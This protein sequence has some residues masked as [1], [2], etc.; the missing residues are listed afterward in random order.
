MPIYEY[1]CETCAKPFALRQSIQIRPGETAC[2]VCGSTHV[3]RLISHFAAKTYGSADADPSGGTSCT[4]GG[5][6]GGN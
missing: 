5:G 1:Q 6:C 2:P 4:R 3:E